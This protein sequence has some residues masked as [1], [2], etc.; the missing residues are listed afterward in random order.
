MNHMKENENPKR[1]GQ[2]LGSIINVPDTFMNFI[3]EKKRFQKSSTITAS[4]KDGVTKIWLPNGR[5]QV[6]KDSAA[7]DV[8]NWK[9][10]ILQR[11]VSVEYRK[12]N[13][14]MENTL[15]VFIAVVE[16][17]LLEINWVIQS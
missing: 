10:T 13:L 1:F 6:M 7:S 16:V 17:V 8:F 12:E 3:I 14:K 4:K 5:N 2:S 11:A 15:N 9:T